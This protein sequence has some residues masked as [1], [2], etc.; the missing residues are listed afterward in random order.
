MEDGCP[1]GVE[2]GCWDG[3]DDGN[4]VGSGFLVYTL[5][6]LLPTT[7]RLVEYMLTNSRLRVEFA[8]S[9]KESSLLHDLPPFR[10]NKMLPAVESCGSPYRREL[11]RVRQMQKTK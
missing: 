11:G 9:M 5:P 7:P 6:P 4:A 8:P 1:D 3:I 2:D 10:V